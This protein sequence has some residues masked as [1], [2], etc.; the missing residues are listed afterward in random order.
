[1]QINYL[2]RVIV[3]FVLAG[4]CV[5]R[6]Q[7]G[8]NPEEALKFAEKLETAATDQELNAILDSEKS[9][10]VANTFLDF[11][12]RR[13]AAGMVKR[14]HDRKSVRQS[15]ISL[16]IAERLGDKAAMGRAAHNNGLALQHVDENHLA[17][18]SY[19]KSFTI[20]ESIPNVSGM[21]LALD[22][23]AK[24]RAAAGQYAAALETFQRALDL[25]ARSENKLDVA[26]LLNNRGNLHWLMGSFRLAAADY[27][28]CLRIS[29]SM[30]SKM[31]M[32]LALNNLSRIYSEQRDL[33]RALDCAQRSLEL[34]RSLGDERGMVTSLTNI[35]VILNNQGREKEALQTI[36]QGIDLARKLGMQP[37]V[38]FGL[39]NRSLVHRENGHLDEAVRD[40]EEGLKL[41]GDRKEY[42]LAQGQI[43]VNLGR[44]AMLRGQM[45]QALEYAT[46]ASVTG[47]QLGSHRLLWQSNEV[48]GSAHQALGQLM[49]AKIAFEQS[50]AAV[51][52][53]RL[54]VVG[55][56]REQEQFLENKLDSY[57]MLAGILISENRLEDALRVAERAK[58]R[59]LTDVLA[60]GRLEITK[61]M[62][63][64]E[65]EKEHLLQRASGPKA[66]AELDAF[67]RNLYASHPELKWQRAQSEPLSL[68]QMDSL[69]PDAKTALLE[70]VTSDQASYLFVLTRKDR[71][72]APQL[73]VYPLSIKG[74]RL[75]E[76]ARRF[77]DQIATRDLG[78]RAAAADL[79]RQLIEPARKE[80]LGKTELV[81]VPDG[82]LWE[83]PFAALVTPR[84]NHIIEEQAIF[85]AQSLTVLRERHRQAHAECF[86][87]LLAMANPAWKNGEG[88]ASFAPIPNAEGEAQS[89]AHLYGE[90]RS[91]VFTGADAR[92]DRF[93]SNASR[94]RVLHL[95][96]HGVLNN[97]NPLE[98]YLALTPGGEGKQEDGLLEVREILDL[99]LKADLVVLSACE[100]ARG[101]VAGGEG[102][103]GM[104]WALSVAGSPAS[105]VSLWKVD[106]SSTSRMM[107]Q[108]HKTLKSSCGTRKARALQQ[109]MA[110]LLATPEY[111]HPYYWAGF[112]LIG[113]GY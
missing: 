87:S 56:E 63:P 23:V 10:V 41:K 91:T 81:I 73:S 14:Q 57:H 3:V 58:A 30:N 72:A 83:L 98:S 79:Y 28:E 38:I 55:A 103:I 20:Y 101:K 1:M 32:G 42:L 36:E 113:D 44:I 33:D 106:S 25:A 31:G 107:V 19:Q 76:S 6:A 43:L 12:N 94:F 29:E 15:S 68:A 78:Y 66:A 109:S 8:L 96:T 39:N 9:L 92:E 69:I 108:F 82:P 2:A 88:R 62:T 26:R 49:E 4:A 67:R 35:G 80:L 85:L 18:E 111:R 93:K 71:S 95:A 105:V 17:Q 48:L 102:V 65:T 21:S 97:E 5:G 100:T 34:K 112:V 59:V 22:G 11:Y 104:S 40:L 89:L 27:Q 24:T 16:T 37:Q 86:P 47:S 46:R 52:A 90:S 13:V 50:I 70:Y 45:K 60:T 99:E 51:D 54:E 74:R 75:A 64:D 110:S 77:R 61:N 84:Q 53:L 7:P